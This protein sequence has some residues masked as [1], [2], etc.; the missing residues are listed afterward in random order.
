M[1]LLDHIPC[2]VGKPMAFK[3]KPT[4]LSRAPPPETKVFRDPP[5]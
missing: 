3:K 2:R 4:S 5:N 1:F